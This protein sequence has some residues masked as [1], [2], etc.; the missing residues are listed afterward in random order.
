MCTWDQ[1]FEKLNAITCL[2]KKE[3]KGEGK[4]EATVKEAAAA[5]AETIVPEKKKEKKE[6]AKKEKKEKAPPAPAEPEQPVVS[7]LDIRVGHIISCKKHE[8]ADALYVEQID[9]GDPEGTPRT[10]VSGLVKWYPLEEMQVPFN[11]N[12]RYYVKVSAFLT[13]FSSTTE[14]HCL[15]FM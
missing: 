3:K 6:K 1:I 5:V 8:D 15:G 14:P 13:V 12:N 2:Q 10:I 9:V 4:I 7:R 11:F